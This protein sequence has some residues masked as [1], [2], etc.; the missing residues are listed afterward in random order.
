MTW[1]IKPTV[2][3]CSSPTHHVRGRLSHLWK[4]PPRLSVRSPPLPLPPPHPPM[5]SQAYCND[6][7]QSLDTSSPS[8]SSASSTLSSPSLGYATGGDIPA[9]VP[10]ALGSAL[11]ESSSRPLGYS[12][13]YSSASS[14]SWTVLTDDDPERDA[15][16]SL[17]FHPSV[18]SWYDGSSKSAN[19]AENLQKPSALSYTRR[20][21]GTNNHSTVPNP[22]GRTSSLH[23]PHIPRSAPMHSHLP[24]YD[25]G[26]ISDSGFSSREESEPECFS[27]KPAIKPKRSRASLP[28]YFS[29]L[30]MSSP[31]GQKRLP[32]MSWSS[33]N[34]MTRR[35]PPTPKISVNAAHQNPSFSPSTIQSLSTPRGRRRTREASRSSTHSKNYS[36]PSPSRS[37]SRRPDP[38]QYAS[39]MAAFVRPSHSDIARGRTSVRRNSSPLAK[40]VLTDK[41]HALELRGRANITTDI[42]PDLGHGRSGLV[43][44][45]RPFSRSFRVV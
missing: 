3:F 19:F 29:L 23:V 16:F 26:P 1:G 21:S 11:T 36:S 8:I 28:G 43:D 17:G 37:R 6:D 18:D 24:T 30:Q 5:H 14:T 35:S 44:R 4:V 38:E 2:R 20:P 7:C 12:L 15:T 42:D 22:H 41:E 25:D 33:E 45:E 27:P 40:M 10:A 39:G 13:S 32:S 34:T 9:L 31:S